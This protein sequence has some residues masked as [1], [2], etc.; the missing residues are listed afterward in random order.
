MIEIVREHARNV[1]HWQNGD[2][3]LRWA[4]AGML[5]ASNPVPPRQGLPAAPPP[6][7]RAPR[8]P[9]APTTEPELAVSA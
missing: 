6:R 2:M 5:T 7:C 8:T 9:S 4:A 3:C 1:K